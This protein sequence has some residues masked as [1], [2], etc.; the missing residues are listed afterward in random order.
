MWAALLLAL[1][2]T[3]LVGFGISR[4]MRALGCDGAEHLLREPLHCPVRTERST[5]KVDDRVVGSGDGV[6]DEHF[7]RRFSLDEDAAGGYV[8]VC[9]F[10]R[11]GH[12]RGCGLRIGH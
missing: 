1:A 4:L 8:Q 3:A 6:A 11:Q 9:A 10:Q 5:K 7:L 12:G 2:V